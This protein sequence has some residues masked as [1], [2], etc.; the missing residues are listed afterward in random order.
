[1]SPGEYSLMIY[2]DLNENGRYDSGYPKPVEFSEPFMI[3]KDK[4]SLR[5]RFD[6]KGYI[7]DYGK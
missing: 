6:V 5:A 4:I 2:E 3:I 1:M 7:I